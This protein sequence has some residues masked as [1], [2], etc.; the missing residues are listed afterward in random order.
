MID[1]S[2]PARTGSAGAG[3]TW[4]WLSR[5]AWPLGVLSLLLTAASGI[6]AIL[7]LHAFR[8]VDEADP[9]SL[10]LPISYAIMGGFLATRHSRN[11]IGWIFLGMAL[12]GSLAGLSNEYV[13]RSSHFHQLPGVAW[14][15]WPH[16]WLIWLVFPAGLASFFFLLFPDG[17]FQSRRWRRL[18]IFAAVLIAMGTVLTMLEKTIEL[19]GS[20]SIRNP[21]I[22]LVNLNGPLGILQ[23][24]PALIVLVAAMVG[25]IL[26]MRRATGETRQ[27]LRWLAYAA[28]ATGVGIV[29]IVVASS[30]DPQLS[31]AWFDLVILL[32]FGIAVPVSCAI[33]I[34]KFGLYDLDI[35]VSKT[36]VYAVLAAFFTAVY[37]AV[38]VG[39]G[40]AVGSRR[41]PFLT[42]VAAALIAVAFNP[43]REQAKH[44]AN[45]LVYGKRASPYE[46]LSE[47]VEQMGV[48][49]SLE[50]VLPRMAAILGEGT[51]ARQA[52]VWLRIGR[53]LRPAA[54]WGE[55]RGG[56]VPLPASNGELP[57]FAGMSK[58]VAVRD[59]GDL[60]GALTL[61]KPLNE[62]LSAAE[63]KLVDHLAAQAG[64]VLRNVRLTEELRANLEELRAS[65]QRIVAAQDAAAR[66]LERNIH[67]GAQQ[68]LVALAVKLRLVDGFVGRDEA[69]AH[70]MLGELQAES[71]DALETLRDLARG[72][73]PP[74]LADRGLLSALEAQARKSPFP[75]RIEA[76]GVGRYPQDQEA[77]L[78]FCALE[79]LQNVTK[80]ADATNVTLRLR[81]SDGRVAFEVSDDGRGFDPS[82]TRQG[83][84]L[85]GMA[86]RMA[87]LAGELVVTSAPGAGTSVVGSFPLARPA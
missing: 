57:D 29:A 18:G 53:E 71:Q 87:A 47:F 43:V 5:V 79:A 37:L 78:Y 14:V 12:C 3:S 39:I 38:V 17:H 24:P 4:R 60:L 54:S 31:N 68:Q 52:L 55:D 46:V 84:G 41:N 40:T 26:R 67:D 66:R 86:D 77:A 56:L 82:T 22:P 8:S 13:F 83:T 9:V 49:Y 15:A 35:V 2:T 32:G 16:D 27:Q 61:T 30:I 7:N 75:I 80:Y 73:Y 74:L 25:V 81:E 36:V 34:L 69:R 44:V 45:R 51:G 20:P 23:W 76:D 65:R 59:G 72:I 85:Q 58:V 62:P 19:T 48:T 42:L 64:L 10:I 28:G 1:V 21:L 11:P 50:D 6:F 70:A 33:A 63:G